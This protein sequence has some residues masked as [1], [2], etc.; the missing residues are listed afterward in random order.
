MK[1]LKFTC[2]NCKN[3]RLEE[4]MV[5]VVVSSEIAV[6]NEDGDITYGE[7]TNEDGEVSQYQCI[8]CGYIVGQE[9]EGGPITDCIEMV[10][11]VKSKCPQD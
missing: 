2:P 9:S 4:I 6:I 8:G 3:H 11:W 5:D 1:N 10:Q 7:Q